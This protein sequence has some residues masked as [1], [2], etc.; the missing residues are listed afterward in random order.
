MQKEVIINSFDNA[1]IHLV[2]YP[3]KNSKQKLKN[4]VFFHGLTTDKN[5][6]LDF[7]KKVAHELSYLG[8]SVVCFDARAHGESDRPANEFTISNLISDGIEVIKWLKN[9]EGVEK[10]SLFG[11]SFGAV[12]SISVSKIVP[13]FI[14]ELYLLAPVI[15]FDQLYLN[16]SNAERFRKYKGLINN[17]FI[18][19]VD[20]PL[21]DRLYFNR[22]IVTEFALIDLSRIIQNLDIKIEIMHGTSDSMV[23][24]EGT[25]NLVLQAA[26]IKLH[27]FHNMDHGFMKI[28]DDEGI[29][30]ESKSNLEKIIEILNK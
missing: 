21:T 30:D 19:G 13:D 28:G 1:K 12:P 25:K 9:I 16:P 18:N 2:Y 4:F 14:N 20:F 17:T 7:Y 23:P 10:V 26:N 11:T 27:T 5:E 24:Y 29:T 6:Y 8:H 15:D 22:F 3:R